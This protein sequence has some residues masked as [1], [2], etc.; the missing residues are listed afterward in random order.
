MQSVEGVEGHSLVTWLPCRQACAL[1]IMPKWIVLI[2][3]Y[4][5]YMHEGLSFEKVVYST[6]LRKRWKWME[7]IS[8]MMYDVW[9]MMYDVWCMMY[10]VC[11]RRFE[12][13]SSLSWA[14]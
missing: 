8:S 2:V 4:I 6:K 12:P 5:S 13:A 1:Q 9:C 7:S 3:D 14:N 10:A 11:N